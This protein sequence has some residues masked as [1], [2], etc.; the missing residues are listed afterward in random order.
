MVVGRV[1]AT[2]LLT[3]A[4]RH[5]RVRDETL[6]TDDF[7]SLRF[8]AITIT[9]PGPDKAILLERQVDVVILILIGRL[10]MDFAAFYPEVFGWTGSVFSF[11]SRGVITVFVINSQNP[12]NLIPV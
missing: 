6:W 3:H 12:G 1:E 5:D 8:A 10:K 4:A 7:G 2:R 9:G 11:Y